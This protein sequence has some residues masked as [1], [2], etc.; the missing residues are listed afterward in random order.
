[1]Y[2]VIEYVDTLLLVI[3]KILSMVPSVSFN[4]FQILLRGFHSRSNPGYSSL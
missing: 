3:V 1:M 2:T 4:L